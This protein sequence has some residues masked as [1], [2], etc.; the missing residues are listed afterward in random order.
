MK[1]LNFYNVKGGAGKSSLSYLTGLYLAGTNSK[2]LFLDLDPQCSLTS[3]FSNEM[4][5][6]TIYNF[7]ADSFPL[8]EMIFQHSENIFYIPSSINVFKIQ[9][10][11]LQNKLQKA[12]KKISSEFDYLIIDNSPN[13]SALS[14]A[15]IQATDILFIPSQVSSF[16]FDSLVFTLQ[17]VNE[18]K[19]DIKINVILN[20]VTKNETRE[21][22]LF[23]NSK[24]LK[25]CIITRFQNQNSIRKFI[26]NKDSLDKP[27]Y[28]KLSE[29][30]HEA[31]FPALFEVI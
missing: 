15:S 20:R 12:I 18:I 4:K 6:R 24:L 31:L 1:V 5:D 29:S 16:D 10:K 3:I 27:K 21:E 14:I 26:S 28:A 19:E 25:D 7:L 13:F 17:E 2:V 9:D 22:T 11:V 8:E 30:I 23:S